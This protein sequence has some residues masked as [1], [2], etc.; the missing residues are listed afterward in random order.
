MPGRFGV[1]C[2]VINDETLLAIGGEGHG[3]RGLPPLLATFT[4][5]HGPALDLHA[6]LG[7]QGMH[8]CTVPLISMWDSASVGRC[9]CTVQVAQPDNLS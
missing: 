3:S 4:I 6:S 2:G 7:K 8:T 5:T 9:V 1:A